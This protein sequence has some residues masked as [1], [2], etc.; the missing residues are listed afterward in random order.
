MNAAFR[1]E[2]W[3]SSQHC[4]GGD[5]FIFLLFQ[6]SL[7]FHN[8]VC[9]WFGVKRSAS[10]TL[11]PREQ[12]LQPG[13]PTGWCL[14]SETG[15]RVLSFQQFGEITFSWKQSSTPL[16]T[17]SSRKSSKLPLRAPPARRDPSTGKG[18]EAPAEMG[19]SRPW[20]PAPLPS[21]AGAHTG[22]QLDGQALAVGISSVCKRE[23]RSQADS[24][25]LRQPVPH[26]EQRCSVC[27]AGTGSG[28]I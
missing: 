17:T 27:C 4:V 11:C 21:S 7:L 24:H 2:T 23:S 26:H 8:I 22:A 18:W 25:R 20:L 3:H 1:G 6:R 12:R 5:K 13:W 14:P 15:L 28:R 9:Y 10:G 19:S 16:L